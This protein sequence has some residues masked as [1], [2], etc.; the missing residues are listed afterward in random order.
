MHQEKEKHP[1]SASP[2]VQT[3]SP[4]GYRTELKTV[5]RLLY[6]QKQHREAARAPHTAQGQEK[7][8]C[9]KNLTWKTADLLY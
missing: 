4:A 3:M 6:M 9:Q 7:P 5:R 8:V 2:H 1:P